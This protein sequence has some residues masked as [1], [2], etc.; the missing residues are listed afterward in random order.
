MS[1]ETH[2]R[3]RQLFDEALTRPE[4]ERTTFLQAACGANTEMLGQVT[5]LLSAHAE[6][7]SFPEAAPPRPQRIGRYVVSG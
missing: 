5:L 1:P 3:A 4:A 6:A 2:Q 7:T